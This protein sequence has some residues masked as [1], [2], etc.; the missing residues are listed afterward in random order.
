M[1]RRSRRPLRAAALWLA[2][3][4][5]LALACAGAPEPA[6]PHL[7]R[8]LE[9]DPA[10]RFR[11]QELIAV[12]EVETLAGGGCL[13]ERGWAVEL[14]PAEYACEGPTLR[15]TPGRRRAVLTRRVDLDAGEVDAFN[16]VVRGVARQT[17]RLEWTTHGDLFGRTW[18]VEETVRVAPESREGH[19]RLRVDGHEGWRG[20]IA[21]LR[22]VLT[23][24][25]RQTAR[26]VSFTAVRERVVPERLEEAA[27]RPWKIDL[28]GQMRGGV[29]G[30]PGRPVAWRTEARRGTELRFAYG[31]HGAC[32]G[33]VRFLVGA[34]GERGADELFSDT[35]SCGQR[36]WREARV[37]LGG[38]APGP[39]ALEFVTA[40]DDGFDLSS[41]VPVW[42]GVELVGGRRPRLLNVVLVSIDTLRADHLSLYGYPRQTTPRLDARCERGAVVFERAVA[43]AP[44]TLP[45]HASLFT[46]LNAE[47]HGVNQNRAVPPS[48]LTLAEILRSAGYATHAVTGGGF[49]HQQYGFAQGFDVYGSFAEKM[50]HDRELEAGVADAVAALETLRERNFFLF[51]HTYA[52]HNPYRPRQPHLER[53]TG[54]ATRGFVDVD[55]LPP[56][57]E[58]GFLARRGL[59]RVQ[60]AERVPV[61]VEQV[62]ELAVDLYDSGIAYMDEGLDRLLAAIDDLGLRERTLIVVTSDH[63][64]L[65]GEHGEVNHHSLYDENVMVPL[66][67][68]DPESE[69]G[70]RRVRGQVRSI[71]VLPTILER[72][73][74][75][76]LEGIDGESLAPLLAAGGGAD[77]RGTGDAWSYASASNFGVSLRTLEGTTYIARNDAWIA[78]G[79]REQ[80]FPPRAG[81]DGGLAALRERTER[82]L[83]EVLDGLRMRFRNPG[84]V[85]LTVRLREPSVPTRLKVERIAEGVV[86]PGTPGG[87]E[88]ALA[89]GDDV[90]LIVEGGSL[91]P[92]RIIVEHP[93]WGSHRIVLDPATLEGTRWIRRT[94]RGWRE[95]DAE[96]PDAVAAFWWQGER[97]AGD[98]GDVPADEDL[99]RQLRALGYLR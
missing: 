12:E 57:P 56:Q 22:L 17:V 88:L 6:Q 15:L 39:L 2:P 71:D 32:T 68:L 7:A 77:E 28:D 46:G 63:G 18:R 31:V 33:S 84:P 62:K 99:V 47:R 4:L 82:H 30:V 44:W 72:L 87:G 49:V 96:T 29:L 34:G 16:L 50:G 53:L 59:V 1:T 86:E 35:L 60:R 58:N 48:L 83:G 95:G 97:V 40:A 64:E 36:G 26:V 79:A 42:G 3:A 41:A 74:M 19:A 14:P 20:R 24:Q 11:Q 98:D 81:E 69:P 37:P 10:R 52:V 21:E 91:R 27:A 5:A 43:S 93:E 76:P 25:A 75:P 66:V 80:V 89:P 8:L 55:V 94:A 65:F 67:F 78:D 51:F 9:Q 70:I 85:P 23:V 73:G 13:A 38:H 61:P 54:R 90:T 45:S 92:L